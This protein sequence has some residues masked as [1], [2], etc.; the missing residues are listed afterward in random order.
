MATKPTKPYA[1]LKNE[2]ESLRA[3]AE[4]ARKREIEGVVKTIK[5]LGLSAEELGFGPAQK[6]AAKTGRKPGRKAAGKRAAGT[7]YRDANGNTWGGR[8]P[9]PLWLRNALA[10]GKSL[11][12]FRA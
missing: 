8:G 7:A 5:E 12:E 6:A 2:I 1:D 9:R 10:A 3:Q 11:D 4:E